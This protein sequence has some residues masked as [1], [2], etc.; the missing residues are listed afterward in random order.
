[1]AALWLDNDVHAMG[2][3]GMVVGGATNGEC[4]L[5][6]VFKCPY[7]LAL[8]LSPAL[9]QHRICD[10]CC[11]TYRYPGMANA[12]EVAF[13]SS[14]ALQAYFENRSITKDDMD[15][16]VEYWREN[17]SEETDPEGR[18]RPVCCENYQ[19][20]WCTCE[21]LY[22]KVCHPKRNIPYGDDDERNTPR[23]REVSEFDYRQLS[24]MVALTT[25]TSL[26]HRCRCDTHPLKYDT[27]YIPTVLPHRCIKNT[28]NVV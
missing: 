19:I 17:I 8:S 1:M 26:D 11:C 14:I 12:E 9:S 2:L 18:K 27:L 20:P 10:D 23:L 6:S 5:F 15:K 16:C 21:Y 24:T 3:F 13:A 7:N 22:D 4:R 28:R 25:V